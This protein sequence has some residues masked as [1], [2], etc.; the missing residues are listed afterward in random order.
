MRVFG[1]QGTL[2][3]LTDENSLDSGEKSVVSTLTVRLRENYSQQIFTDIETIQGVV[4]LG[5]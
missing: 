3:F 5:V 4:D 2:R 1:V